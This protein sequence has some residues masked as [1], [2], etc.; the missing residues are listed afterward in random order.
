MGVRAIAM[1]SSSVLAA[2]FSLPAAAASTAPAAE[3]TATV[4]D[5]RSGAIGLLALPEVFGTEPCQRFRAQPVPVYAVAGASGPIGEIRTTS[6]W[7]YAPDGGCDGLRVEFVPADGVAAELPA[8]D[9]D[10]ERPAAIVLEVRGDW[11]RVRLPAGDGWL[12]AAGRDEFVP[13]Q[14][15]LE[16]EAG[17]FT[18]PGAT[19]LRTAPNDDAA[20]AWSGTPACAIARVRGADESAGRRW[21]EIEL[22]R[23]DCCAED[24]VTEPAAPIR[25]WLPLRR[26][27]GVPSVWIAS[28]GC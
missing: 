4:V 3:E 11:Y 13:L 27:D 22:V 16:R 21:L 9:Y 24:A 20:P 26:D 23:D 8:Q 12:H 18:A 10:S 2:A 19:V 1:L 5:P 15:L 14:V 28:R 7:H 17:A 25:G 6:G